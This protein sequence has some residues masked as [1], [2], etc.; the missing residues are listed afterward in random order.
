[1]KIL[2]KLFVMI[3]CFG[4]FLCGSGFNNDYE[5]I[6]MIELKF[7]PITGYSW[8]VTT[9]DLE[10]EHKGK[11]DVIQTYN[12]D[13]ECDSICGAGGTATFLSRE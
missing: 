7:N 10:L 5:N 8:N 11:V 12:C 9:I 4:L 6:Q 13:N 3:F 2:K 1:M